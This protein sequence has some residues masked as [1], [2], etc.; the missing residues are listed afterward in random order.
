MAAAYLAAFASSS[1]CNAR[2]C[3]S[4]SAHAFRVSCSWHETHLFGPRYFGAA[5]AGLPRAMHE[6]TIHATRAR[7]RKPGERRTLGIAGWR[8]N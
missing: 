8:P 1:C 2:E 3:L 7:R 4:L 6:L 5:A